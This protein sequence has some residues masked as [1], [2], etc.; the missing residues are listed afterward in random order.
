MKGRCT[1]PQHVNHNGKGIVVCTRWAT[2]E[3]FFEDMGHPPSKYYNLERIDN[4]L[5]YCKENCKWATRKEQ[6]NNT[7]RNVKVEYIGKT[8]TIA[9]WAE[10]FKIN[11]STFRARYRRGWTMAR[12]ISTPT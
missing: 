12:I 9:Q 2:F 4:N 7:S 6:S 10:E 5:N 3:N 11:Y 8:Q 1:H